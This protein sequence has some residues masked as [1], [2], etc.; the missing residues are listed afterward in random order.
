VTA[1]VRI[2]FDR[3]MARVRARRAT[4]A[5]HD[6]A[7]RL[8]S[9]GVHV[10]FGEG[11]FTDGSTVDVDGTPL[12]FGRAVIATGA[13]PAIPP[14]PGLETIPYLTNE[15]V[16][17]LRDQPRRLV[18]LGA[19]PIGC[20]LAQA[21]ARLGSGVTLMDVSDRVLPNDDPAAAVIIERRLRQEG[22]RLELG[23]RVDDVRASGEGIVGVRAAGRTA[24]GDAL[25]VAAGRTANVETLQ[26]DAAGV[27]ADA[28]GVMVNDRLQ[29]S[30][31]RI[32]ASGDV[33]SR[34]R[35]THAADAM[36]RLVL[37]N[38]LFFG[39]GRASRLVIPWV[40]YTD[41]EVAHVGVTFQ[42]VAASDGR[43]ATITIP[44]SDVDRAIVDDETDGFVAVHHARG[45]L[46]GCT[47]VA[48]HAGEMIAE[49]VYALT[50]GGTL[51][52]LSAT[53][54]PYPTQAEALRKAGDEY[55]R[56]SLTPGIRRLLSRYFAW[57]R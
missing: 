17:E 28:R 43:L 39:R 11:R 3:V 36:S 57:T 42:D 38:A 21:F 53:V 41:P 15:T 31:R 50:H 49:A 1:D 55:R 20:E 19:G 35:F 32:F 26:L 47:I 52:A 34:Y 22:V 24:D 29:S 9:A 45:R 46:R 33:C 18:I 37:G 40:T 6:A 8:A 12:R 5:A 16:F 10:F 51:A 23:A 14:I 48:A 2:D 44:L 56:Q 4:I 30:N 54:H 7:A 13:R 25:L 27:R